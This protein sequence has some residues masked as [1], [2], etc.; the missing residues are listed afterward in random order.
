MMA[1]TV[2]LLS[3]AA[4]LAA[5]HA[6]AAVCSTSGAM[7]CTCTAST[8]DLYGGCGWRACT[9]AAGRYVTFARTLENRPF[10]GATQSAQFTSVP[11]GAFSSCTAVRGLLCVHCR[12]ACVK[13]SRSNVLRRY[14][15]GNPLG[16]AGAIQAGSFTGLG[17]IHYL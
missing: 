8:A 7:S 11:I 3:C 9:V 12:H 15:Q 14:L 16:S 1:L 10:L 5:V 2:A 4:I 13:R 17:G 6:D